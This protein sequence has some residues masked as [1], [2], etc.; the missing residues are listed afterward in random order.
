MESDERLYERLRDGALEAFD[1]L[2]D[3]YERPLFAFVRALSGDAAEAEDVFHESF[4]EVLRSREV[5]FSQGSFKSWIYR[6]ARNR[7]LNRLRSRRRGERALDEWAA[8]E[9]AAGEP[10]DARLQARQAETALGIAVERLPS[11]L[12]EVYRLRASGLSYEEMASVLA[13]PLGT[14]RSR[15]HEMVTRLQQEMKSWTAR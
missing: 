5:D 11:R 3:R 7:C 6:I 4:L 9:P 2:Y 14:V 15:I 13:V 10:A 8:G 12:S 1:V